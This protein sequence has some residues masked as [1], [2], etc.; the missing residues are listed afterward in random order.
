MTCFADSPSSEDGSFV[1]ATV[2]APCAVAAATTPA[3]SGDAPDC[4]IPI[5][6]APR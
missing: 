6:S 1:I 3:T 5:T 2:T 4:E